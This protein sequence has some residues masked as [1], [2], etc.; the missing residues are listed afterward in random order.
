M[1]NQWGWNDKDFVL[2]TTLSNEFSLIKI[3]I[4][5]LKFQLTVI[6]YWF[7]S[8]LPLILL[9]SVWAP[10]RG[11][12]PV[13]NHCPWTRGNIG[14]HR[15]MRTIRLIGYGSSLGDRLW[16][17]VLFA[18]LDL[19]QHWLRY[20]LVASWHQATTWTNV[21]LSPKVFYGIHLR[22]IAQ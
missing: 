8:L 7:N 3:S 22:A 2:Q 1:W 11:R 15:G 18:A 12:V 21:D 6:T 17:S 20:W 9:L 19:D 4:F 13:G 10:I 5:N 16:K 14:P